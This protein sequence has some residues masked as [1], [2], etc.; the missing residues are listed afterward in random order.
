M[1]NFKRKF[2]V[3]SSHDDED[4]ERMRNRGRIRP[5]MV[6]VR[7]LVMNIENYSFVI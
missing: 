3:I 5:D 2:S 4:D 6:S 1:S 7:N